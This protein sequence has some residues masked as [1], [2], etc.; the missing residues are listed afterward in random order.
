MKVL[1]D[2]GASIS[3]ITKTGLSLLHDVKIRPTTVK[4]WAAN[5]QRIPLAGEVTLRIHLQNPIFHRFVITHNNISGCAALLGTDIYHKLDSF[6]LAGLRDAGIILSLNGDNFSLLCSRPSHTTYSIIAKTSPTPSHFVVLK[7]L[8]DDFESFEE[9]HPITNLENGFV[10]DVPSSQSDKERI[11]L[12]NQMLESFDFSHLPTTTI[13]QVKAILIQNRSLFITS[14]SDPC[15]LIPNKVISINTDPGEPIRAKLRR[16]SPELTTKIKEMNQ[17]MLQRGIIEKSSSDWSNPVVLVQRPDSS[18]TLRLCLDLRRLNAR[19]K[20]DAFPIPDIKTILHRVAGHKFYTTVDI[21]EAYFCLSIREKDRH[22]IAFRTPDGLYQFTRLPFGIQTGCAIWNRAFQ[23]ILENLGPNVQSYFDD[24]I[25]FTNTLSDHLSY[26]KATLKTLSKAGLRIKLTKCQ[27]VK[28]KVKFL[29]F[30][31]SC[32]G[33]SPTADGV[34][35]VQS[36]KRPETLKQ[37][38]SFLGSINYYREYI[39]KFTTMA[40]PLYDLTKK[41]NKFTWNDEANT[42]WVTLKKSLSSNYILIPPQLNKPYY[43]ATDATRHTIAG[44]LLQ[45]INDKLRPIE[46]FSRRLKPPETRYHTNEI[47]GLAIFASVKRWQHFLLFSEFTIFTDNSA[48]THLF[49]RKE[50]INNRVARWL[51]FLASFKYKVIHIKGKDNLLPDHLS[52]YVDFDLLEKWEAEDN[53][54]FSV[55]TSP[56]TSSFLQHDHT[57]GKVTNHPILHLTTSPAPVQI[58]SSIPMKSLRSKQENDPIWLQIINYLE[59]RLT[60]IQE[61]PTTK[62]PC[63]SNFT[64]NKDNILCLQV[65]NG[66][67]ILY[68]PVVPNCYIPLALAHLH[69]SPLAA[70]PSPRQTRIAASNTF[71]WKSMLSDSLLYS[72]SCI[73]CQQFREVTQYFPDMIGHNKLIP[74]YPSECL[75]MDVTYMQTATTG[76]KYILSIMDMYSRYTIFYPLR[77]MYA[78]TISKR[79]VEHCCNFGFPK[80]IVTDDANNISASLAR[81]IL[82]LL[83]IQHSITIPYRHNPLMV[84]RI[85]HPLKQAL[86]IMCQGAEKS[87]TKYLKKVN[88]ALNARHNSTLNCSPS[89]AFFMRQQ[90]PQPNFND[91]A[92][93]PSCD[94]DL[95]AETTQ[96]RKILAKTSESKKKDYNEKKNK[97]TKGP[98]LLQPGNLVMCKRLAYEE[99]INR[100]MQS[101]RTGPWVITV[102]NG[103]EILIRLINDPQ[104]VRRRHI[105]HLAPFISR[106][107]HLTLEVIPESEGQHITTNENPTETEQQKQPQPEASPLLTDTDH[108]LTPC[109]PL[110][111]SRDLLQFTPHSMTIIGIE[112]HLRKAMGLAKQILLKYPQTSPY[113]G[114]L[115]IDK[116]SNDTLFKLLRNRPPARRTPGSY[117]LKYPKTRSQTPLIAHLTIQYLPGK[118]IDNGG[119]HGE[120]LSQNHEH[121]DAYLCSL[122]SSD[123]TSQRLQWLSQALDQL[124]NHILTSEPKLN[125]IF[126]PS[127]LGCGFSGGDPPSYIS[128]L[129]QFTTNLKTIGCKVLLIKRPDQKIYK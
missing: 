82:S 7:L 81:D 129:N 109:H 80:V 38:R 123:T 23:E 50:P 25:I 70:H 116:P 114:S 44:V 124:Y 22:K 93:T 59:Q 43:I 29:G 122:I 9:I 92:L 64:L 21:S 40:V 87:W 39:P 85:H 112:C 96:F 90:N 88:Y 128:I 73:H 69:D 27:L 97:K 62:I 117:I 98:P 105:S 71:Y 67:D 11:T 47:E 110:H 125:N 102:V 37:L 101:R 58:W 61:L 127:T 3:L 74:Q 76:E 95:I 30:S 119:I 57:P 78:D 60:N 33:S 126:I 36:L 108:N 84:E 83:S 68:K 103:S 6:C 111:L 89:Q 49:N 63:L 46:Y 52:R 51:V 12:F 72:R 31:I 13:D 35:S 5:N 48:M 1:F 66:N 19:I 65:H 100:K 17:L 94:P 118:A 77:D 56:G 42:A 121:M 26:L 8:S 104:V 55:T 86:S 2:S 14:P 91:I 113:S 106:P 79:L 15:G 4:V 28:H 41:H 107:Q 75:S 34:R 10:P 120:Y 45:K 24:L 32:A 99:G 18:T 16:Y 53:L 115:P 54:L 20:F